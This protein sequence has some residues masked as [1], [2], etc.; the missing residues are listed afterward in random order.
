MKKIPLHLGRR[1]SLVSS[2]F[3][4]LPRKQIQQFSGATRLNDLQ[5]VVRVRVL[6]QRAGN[7]TRVPLS[8][9][10]SARRGVCRM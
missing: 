3:A 1:L 6:S 5:R 9:L 7:R 10:A 2:L 4:F 8:W